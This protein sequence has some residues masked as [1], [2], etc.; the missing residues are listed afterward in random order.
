MGKM[1]IIFSDHQQ[2]VGTAP[3]PPA[4][5]VVM[6]AGTPFVDAEGRML[7][8]DGSYRW[9]L[10]GRPCF[11]GPDGRTPSFVPMDV[12]MIGKSWGD[13]AATTSAEHPHGILRAPRPETSAEKKAREKA[14]ADA[15]AAVEAARKANRS[16]S[17]VQ[18]RFAASQLGLR[19]AIEALVADPATPRAFRDYWEYSTEYRRSHPIWPEALALIGKTEADLDALYD[20]GETL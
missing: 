1:T 20:L 2:P 12:A 18:I 9:N 19:D 11:A 16:L 8:P 7:S 13:L 4:N 3:P 5:H 14:A 6:D 15:A 10:L 17:P